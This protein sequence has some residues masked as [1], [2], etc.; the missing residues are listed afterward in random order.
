MLNLKLLFNILESEGQESVRVVLVDDDHRLETKESEFSDPESS[1]VI[2]EASLVGQVL[3]Q[4]VQS[5]MSLWELVE[6]VAMK[7]ACQSG[8][9]W[10]QADVDFVIRTGCVEVEIQVKQYRTYRY[11]IDKETLIEV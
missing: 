1:D 10:S 11:D 7:V 5:D 4:D 6:C 8:E 9:D 3:G 2:V